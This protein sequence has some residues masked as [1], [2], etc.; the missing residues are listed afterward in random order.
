MK[1]CPNCGDELSHK[2]RIKSMI[3]YEVNCSN[4]N[5]KYIKDN[6]LIEWLGMI[7]ALVIFEIDG[8]VS[9]V[10]A[11]CIGLLTKWI[12]YRFIKYKEVN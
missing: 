9:L 1:C 11:L 7:I 12:L 4:C 6:K 10:V 8:K 2:E 5:A 3:D